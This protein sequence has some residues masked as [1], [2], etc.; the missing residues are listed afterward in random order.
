MDMPPAYFIRQ[1]ICTML[2]LVAIVA[3][4]NIIVDPYLL[5]D[6]PR[7]AEFNARKPA[8]SEQEHL[9]KA[10]EVLR[11]NPRTLL[12][13]SSSVAMG[14]DARSTA[15]RTSERPVYNLGLPGEGVFANR[16]YLQHVLAKE[17]PNTVFLGLSFRDFLTVRPQH[18]HPF[19]SRLAM[20]SGGSPNPLI[21]RQLVKDVLYA[22]LS[23]DSLFESFD[24]LRG[25]LSGDSYDTI[26]GNV[27]PHWHR[28]EISRFGTYPLIVLTDLNYTQMYRD[29]RVDEDVWEQVRLIFEL[30]RGH[31]IS[32]IV[33]LEPAHVDELELADIA[34]K[35]G[36]VEEWKRQLSKMVAKYEA[37]QG[38]FELWDFFGYNS[39]STE[40]VPYTKSPLR[41]FLTP[42]HYTQALGDLMLERIMGS[43][44][45]SF[46]V[47]LIPSNIEGHLADIR[48]AR[49]VYR[50]TQRRDAERVRILYAQIS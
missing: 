9:I 18:E 8:I 4:I 36:A 32:L 5:F 37:R 1:C 40:S 17:H 28:M 47:K 11:F 16:R 19:E 2:T 12:L 15:W 10:Y 45:P 26:S 48:H 34:G 29:S 6:L 41:W 42:S 13:G 7:T 46:G 43:G 35:W 44:D 50:E 14:L 30:C 20:S 3:G 38:H 21:R 24:T 31:G 49:S 23:L 33:I 22:T 25:N 27:D 39:Y